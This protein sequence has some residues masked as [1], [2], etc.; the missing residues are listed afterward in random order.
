MP[1]RIKILT[2]NNPANIDP[3][4]YRMV[5]AIQLH[6]GN[7][8][9]VATGDKL[10]ASAQEC[11]LKMFPNEKW[12]GIVSNQVLNIMTCLENDQ[13]T[14]LGIHC[15][16]LTLHETQQ[17]IFMKWLINARPDMT[18]IIATQSH[19]ILNALRI[20]VKNGDLPVDDVEVVFYDENNC[21]VVCKLTS[22]GRFENW[23]EGFFDQ[24]SFDLATL[25]SNTKPR[26]K[27]CPENCL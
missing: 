3:L 13:L 17:S 22:D 10:G 21:K 20:S 24:L 11:F 23:H 4:L 5:G 9:G 2:S 26:M 8:N 18:L 1:V 25:A 19:T 27:V 12:Y 6:N 7:L 15:P 14:T 16:E